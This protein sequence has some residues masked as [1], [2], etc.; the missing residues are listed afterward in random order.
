MYAPGIRSSLIILY[1]L[2]QAYFVLSPALFRAKR[3]KMT[4]E[5]KKEKKPKEIKK[6]I[7]HK[8]GSR[9]GPGVRN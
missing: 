6:T 4:S 8:H 2:L 7:V 1:L 5:T 9:W 3:A